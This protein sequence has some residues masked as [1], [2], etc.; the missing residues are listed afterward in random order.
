MDETCDNFGYFDT[1]F[2]VMG[3][4]NFLLIF[5]RGKAGN[6]FG[7]RM[8][9]EVK[10]SSESRCFIILNHGGP[11]Q[12]RNGDTRASY[13]IYDSDARVIC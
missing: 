13:A 5:S 2:C 4:S 7:N 3:Y 10:L 8:L 11:G 9:G 12:P 6:C 1:E